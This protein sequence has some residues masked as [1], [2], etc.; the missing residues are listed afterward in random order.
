MTSLALTP[1]ASLGRV[2]LAL[3]GLPVFGAGYNLRANGVT[4]GFEAGNADTAVSVV[5]SGDPAVGLVV[6]ATYTKNTLAVGRVDSPLGSGVA[7]GDQFVLD[8]YISVVQGQPPVEV[9]LESDGGDS[10]EH[11]IHEKITGTAPVWKRHRLYFQA[12]TTSIEPRIVFKPLYPYDTFA[13][14]MWKGWSIYRNDNV[15]GGTKRPFDDRMWID[16]TDAN[17]TRRLT[18]PPAPRSSETTGTLTVQDY[19]AALTGTVSY[20]VRDTYGDTTTGSTTVGG[21][22][23]FLS[24]SDQGV[25]DTVALVTRY[26][27]ARTATGTVHEVIARTHPV[28]VTGPLRARAGTLD[29][30]STTRSDALSLLEILTPGTA[31]L[32]RQPDYADLDLRFVP[33]RVTESPAEVGE[34]LWMLSVDYVEVE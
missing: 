22:A 30:F 31:V 24:S 2:T 29:L 26:D 7:V 33:T 9:W 18:L 10:S 12:D 8:V 25:A 28:V 23:T 27:G 13:W 32:L 3:T 15:G 14:V 21:T 16:R 6:D 34:D 17:G 20:S 1:S 11:V 4:T 19:E 5:Q